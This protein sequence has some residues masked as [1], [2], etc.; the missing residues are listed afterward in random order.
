MILIIVIPTNT[1]DN[2][3]SINIIYIAI[4]N[5]IPA[6]KNKKW[7]QRCHL[8]ANALCIFVTFYFSEYIDI[9]LIHRLSTDF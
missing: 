3:D 5:H 4:S 7:H 6:S 9:T 2:V 1:E 8:I